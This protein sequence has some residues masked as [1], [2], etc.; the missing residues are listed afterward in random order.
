MWLLRPLRLVYGLIGISTSHQVMAKPSR[1]LMESNTWLTPSFKSC[2]IGR[3]QTVNL[4]STDKIRSFSMYQ[5][6]CLKFLSQVVMPCTGA[7]RG[8][9]SI[10]HH[11]DIAHHKILDRPHPNQAMESLDLA[12]REEPLD[13]GMP[14]YETSTYRQMNREAHHRNRPKFL[15]SKC[16][17][18]NSTLRGDMP[19]QQPALN[20]K[21]TNEGHAALQRFVF[22]LS[23]RWTLCLR[24]AGARK[25]QPRST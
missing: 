14:T 21:S 17:H 16:H 23:R 25:Q 19:L 5:P 18:R 15:A 20:R 11:N 10:E 4:R 3:S 22:A 9:M 8:L 6:L 7:I 13:D 1:C 24:P 12:G 2:S